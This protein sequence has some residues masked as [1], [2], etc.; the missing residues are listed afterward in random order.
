[1]PKA[2]FHFE[3]VLIFETYL[4]LVEPFEQ[5]QQVNVTFEVVL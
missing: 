1:M 3:P 2:L 5:Q 4:L